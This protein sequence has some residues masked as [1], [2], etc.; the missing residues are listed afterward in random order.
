MADGWTHARL[1]RA[2]N[3]GDLVLVRRGWYALPGAPADVVEAVRIGG[4]L[5]C[6]RA[7]ARA[8]VWTMPE[9]VVHVAVPANAARLRPR[10]GAVLHWRGDVRRCAVAPTAAALAHLAECAT[11]EVAVAAIDS[12]LNQRLVTRDELDFTFASATAEARSALTLADP[13]AQSGLET[14][15]RLRLRAQRIRYRTQVRIDGVGFVDLLVGRRLVV[16]LDGYEFHG[17]DA[18]E[19]D[20]R[21]DLVLNRLGYRVLRLSYRQLMLDWDA[22]EQTILSLVRGRA[23]R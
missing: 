7:L 15:A 14:F 22:A 2:R 1:E 6:G 9:P 23:H 4:A 13:T 16:E 11:T 20:R 3:A 12:A 21:R 17:R 8:K 19:E 10:A 18:F 5:T